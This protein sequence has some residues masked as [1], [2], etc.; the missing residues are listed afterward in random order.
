MKALIANGVTS[1]DALGRLAVLSS[2]GNGSVAFAINDL[3]A[4][5]K[6]D[7]V[8]FTQGTSSGNSVFGPTHYSP[9]VS[10]AFNWTNATTHSVLVSQ[11]SGYDVYQTIASK[12]GIVYTVQLAK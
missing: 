6:Q 3:W 5:S 4:N 2:V 11:G 7:A 9:T 1:N 10:F 12:I 8:G